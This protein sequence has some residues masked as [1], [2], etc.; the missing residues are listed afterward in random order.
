V[1]LSRILG[2]PRVR[3]EDAR[4]TM[5]RLY[6]DCDGRIL[7]DLVWDDR[8]D[9]QRALQAIRSDTGEVHG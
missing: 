2:L 3:R 1:N 6:S 4:D 7:T 5:R 9:W 8:D